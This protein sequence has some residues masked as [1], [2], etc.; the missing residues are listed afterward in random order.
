MQVAVVGAG[1]I[2]AGWATYFLAQG[3][4]VTATDPG[5]GAESPS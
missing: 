4:A 1:V 3:F 2:N 5:E